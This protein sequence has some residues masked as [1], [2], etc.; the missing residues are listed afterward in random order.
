M[1]A[2]LDAGSE[3]F[4]SVA[5]LGLFQFLFD[6]WPYWQPRVVQWFGSWICDFQSPTHGQDLIERLMNEIATGFLLLLLNWKIGD[7]HSI[8]IPSSTVECFGITILFMFE[9]S[10]RL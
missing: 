2:S 6:V 7:Y 10:R 3:C 5:D 4:S 9:S 8:G 1:R